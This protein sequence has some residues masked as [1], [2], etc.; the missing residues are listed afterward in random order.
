MANIT[1]KDVQA[2]RQSTGLG[3]MDCK[4]ALVEADGD[5]EA[6]V[7][8]LRE[9]GLAT[10]AKKEGRIAAE[11]IVDIMTEGNT[12]AMIEV[13]TETDFVAKNENFKAFV[14]GLLRTLVANKPADMDAFKALPFDGTETSV[15]DALVEKIAVI[16]EKIS[17]RRFVIVEGT[18]STYIH[19]MGTT[20]VIVKFTAD[21]A[22][23]NTPAFAEMAKNIALQIAA[24][25]PPTYVAK[26]DVPQSA[27]DEELAIQ[28]AA[29]KN[30]PAN[31]TKPD[32]IIEKIVLGRLGK[33]FF[34]KVCLLE[35]T[36]VKDDSMSVGKYVDSVA[37]TLGGAVKVDS[38]CI[39]EKGEGIQKR[40]EDFAS[41]I[42][43]M[44]NKQ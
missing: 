25:S 35:Q 15:A 44:V 31:A 14:K 6:A 27:I 43:K 32:A 26:S 7:K 16:G 1:A 11:G 17:L 13:N 37:K 8:I 18:T 12:T 4:K 10:A 21:E 2:L 34:E 40:E 19:G 23:V 28:V 36:Y 3:M 33:L 42:E 41:E 5:F 22:V 20:G 24:G 30:E 9:K 39:F 38:F 29:A